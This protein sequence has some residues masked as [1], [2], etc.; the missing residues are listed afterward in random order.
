MVKVEFEA[1]HGV[2][3]KLALE[4]QEA[5]VGGLRTRRLWEVSSWTEVLQKAGATGTRV[6]ETG[7][8]MDGLFGL[9]TLGTLE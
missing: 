5:D 7:K 4:N 9:G 6:E 3:E 8:W 1:R 2:I